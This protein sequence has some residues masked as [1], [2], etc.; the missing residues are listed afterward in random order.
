MRRQLSFYE[1]ELNPAKR[2]AK[3]LER[4]V[5]ELR[6]QLAARVTQPEGPT[7]YGL[8][9]EE[10][11]FDTVKS[12]AEK[13]SSAQMKRLQKTIDD[14][15]KKLSEFES[16]KTQMAFDAKINEHRSQVSS[17]LDGI[18]PDTLF[19]HPKIAEWMSAQTDEEAAA[20]SNPIAYSAK[21]VAATLRRFNTEV[22]KGQAKREP[23]HGESAV[24]ARVAPDVVERKRGDDD[25][26]VAFNPRTFQADVNKLISAG[27]TADAEKLIKQAER[28]VNA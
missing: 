5:E 28:A 15:N 13:V 4:E 26:G 22:V 6:A 20:L 7:D 10:Q 1:Q 3:E 2:H 24:P 27:R 8:T 11:E 16:S 21:F 19:S 17:L 25:S 12:I 14:M 9:E 18:N 23:S